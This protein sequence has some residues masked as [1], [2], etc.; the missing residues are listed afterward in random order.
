M[1]ACVRLSLCEELLASVML[2][3]TTLPQAGVASSRLMLIFTSYSLVWKTHDAYL[4]RLVTA[5]S[6][7]KLNREIMM[8]HVAQKYSNIRKRVDSRV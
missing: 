1:C 4:L 7:S 2:I 5:S 3:S 6:N 8:L